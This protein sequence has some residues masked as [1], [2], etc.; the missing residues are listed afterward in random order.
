VDN[1]NGVLALDCVRQNDWWDEFWGF[2]KNR[3]QQRHETAQAAKK[4]A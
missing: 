4:A 3:R 2:V 1:L